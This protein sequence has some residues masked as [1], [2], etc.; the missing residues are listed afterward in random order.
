MIR[1]LTLSGECNFGIQS[2][3]DNDRVHEFFTCVYSLF[4]IFVKEFDDICRLGSNES[5]EFVAL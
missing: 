5:F 2:F 3:L 1:A 4:Y